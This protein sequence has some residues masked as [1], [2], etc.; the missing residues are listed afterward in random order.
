MEQ[1][2]VDLNGSILDSLIAKT[3]SGGLKWVDECGNLEIEYKNSD[4]MIMGGS[5]KRVRLVPNKFNIIKLGDRDIHL[6]DP[7]ERKKMRELQALVIDKFF[8]SNGKYA[9]ED[10]NKLLRYLSSL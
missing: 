9:T 5:M 6:E 7:L 8:S 3:K 1:S 10:K 2:F 4:L